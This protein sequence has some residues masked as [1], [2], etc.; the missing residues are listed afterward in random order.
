VNDEGV[1]A[2]GALDSK[3]GVVSAFI[4]VPF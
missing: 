1:I 4:A 2:G 3:T